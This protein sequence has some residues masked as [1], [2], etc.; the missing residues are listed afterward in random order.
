MKLINCFKIEIM[1]VLK[2][3][4]MYILL[5]VTTISN[6]LAYKGRIDMNS[7][8]DAVIATSYSVQAIMLGFMIIGI[9]MERKEEKGNMLEV[10]KGIN[11]AVFIKII[12]KILAIITLILVYLIINFIVL[13]FAYKTN[14]INYYYDTFLYIILFWGIPF[15]ISTLSGY[16]I[17]SIFKGK[18][19]YIVSVFVW[20]LCTPINELL[21]TQLGT[22]GMESAFE[23]STF[24]NLTQSNPEMSVNATYGLNLEIY[25]LYKRLF[26]IV[27]IL[28]FNALVIYKKRLQ[29]KKTFYIS[30]SILLL[31][32]GLTGVLTF[33]KQQVLTYSNQRNS[34]N[35]QDI[36]YYENKI[37]E[38]KYNTNIVA[39]D[40]EMN[41]NIGNIISNDVNIK[42]INNSEK[43]E[44]N[45]HFLLYHD[46]EV[47]EVIINDEKSDFNRDGDNLTIELSKALKNKEEID[48]NI[49]Y[50]GVNS[51]KYFAN[52]R[53][54]YL[55]NYYPWYPV[56]S[57]FD[58]VM[59]YY[60]VNS[61][62]WNNYINQKG[63]IKY[64]VKT[65]SSNGLY[66]NLNKVSDDTFEGSSDEGIY[67]IKGITLESQLQNREY[68]Y[69]L[70]LE[71]KKEELKEFDSNLEKVIGI[72]NK[73]LNL[74]NNIDKVFIVDS[75]GNFSQESSNEGFLVKGALG[76]SY[77]D[78]NLRNFKG[79]LSSIISSLTTKNIKIDNS[80]YES[81]ML[82]DF[83]YSA[84]VGERI[85]ISI[86]LSDLN[87]YKE[88]LEMNVE[89]LNSLGIDVKNRIILVNDL[90]KF[91]SDKKIDDDIKSDFFRNQYKKI[92]SGDSSYFKK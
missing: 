60:G 86:D 33:R 39:I 23:V 53:A 59:S 75:R 20:F 85:G 4:L 34:V 63:N 72:V 82:F 76:V 8:Y 37:T 50:K 15:F 90:I 69:P 83:A 29:T 67:F 88:N 30:I 48:I 62:P 57:S 92:K 6:Y 66:T 41:L 16:L 79:V 3:K 70:S 84:Y 19:V 89:F 44:N 17:S 71:N 64:K 36:D 28:I 65:N 38:S 55:P 52:N 54:I 87:Y 24:L 35:K 56:V 45:I 73:D 7:P 42:M 40:Y 32:L 46:L 61:L 31:L 2:S 77:K 47:E 27:V 43:E 14:Y 74:N 21:F 25:Q 13:I 68:I 51:P 81:L 11:S 18:V 91:I 5:I 80:D 9:Y 58:S 78:Y 1:P 49:K 26:I 10:L 22:L 12:A